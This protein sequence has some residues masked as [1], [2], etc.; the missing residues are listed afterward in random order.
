LPSISLEEGLVVGVNVFLL[1]RL[2]CW[3]V[4]FLGCVANSGRKRLDGPDQTRPSDWSLW[5]KFCIDYALDTPLLKAI[6]ICL[7]GQ[8]VP[9]FSSRTGVESYTWAVTRKLHSEHI[10][11]HQSTHRRS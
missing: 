6:E 2:F 9:F 1:R 5:T 11:T 10:I 3:G 4:L 8:E 7:C